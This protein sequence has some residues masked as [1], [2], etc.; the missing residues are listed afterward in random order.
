MKSVLQVLDFLKIQSNNSQNI[1]VDSLYLDSRKCNDLSVFVAIKGQVTDGNKYIEDVL[2]K[3][4]KLVLTDKE[5]PRLASQSTPSLGEGE[6]PAVIYVEDLKNKLATLAQWFYD[7]KKPENVVGITGTNGK[8]S[9]SNYISQL[10]DLDNQKALLLGTN[11]NGIYPDLKESTHTTLDVLSL[12]SELS[13]HKNYQNLVMEVSSHALDQQ[14]TKGLDFDVA[15]FSNLSHDHLDYHKTMDNYFLAKAQLF[16]FDNLKK[17]VI[18]ID[19]E[20]GLKLCDMCSCEVVTV[21]LKSKQADVYIDVKNIK[22]MTTSFELFL[23]Q[24][25]EG[26]FTTCLVGDFN[27]T[28]LALSIAA[29]DG[30]V[31]KNKF[32]ASVPKVKPVKGRM[33]II[34]LSSGAKI[35]IDYAHTPDALEKALLS[36]RVYSQADLW[37]IFGCGGDRDSSKRAKMAT[38][39]EK[40]ADEIVVT[41]DNNRFEDIENIFDDIR[42][43]FSNYHT[44]IKSREEAINYA[45]EKSSAQDIILLSGKGHEC[46]L[47]KNGVKEF[48]DERE[49]IKRAIS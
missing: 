12:Y 37:C 39:V 6:L 9:I 7:Y 33:E 44:F 47:D 8:T 24:K 1:P 34:N 29:C 5:L 21:S 15:V 2:A 10:L 46:Y 11:G 45:I 13:D 31:I 23:N 28:N 30:Q 42:E 32:L 20:Y 38:I 48:F 17:A 43:G 14:R 18:N 27:L 49:V 22:N 40:Y 36:L 26:Y 16:K 41:E 19:D 35:V 3:G 25:S 4:V